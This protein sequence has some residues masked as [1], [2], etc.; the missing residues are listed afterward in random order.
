[1]ESAVITGATGAIGTALINELVSKGVRVLVLTREDSPRNSRIPQSPLVEV[2]YCSLENLHNLEI[3]GEYDVFYH[4]AWAGTFGSARNDF[5]LQNKNVEYALDAVAAAKRMGCR[6]FI[7]AGS[8][9]E[10]GR[11][12]G[13]LKPDTPAFPE[14]GY[15]YAK[16]CAGQMTRDFAHQLGLRH[17][18]VRIL[19]VYGP[20][21][22]SGT[23]VMS[24]L[25]KLRDGETPEFTKGEQRWDYLYS[26]DAAEAF[27]MLGEKGRD[28]MVYVLGSGIARP[29]AEYIEEIRQAAAP[30]GSV[31]LGAVPYGEKQVMFL[32]ADISE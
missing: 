19:S 16:L 32:C 5:Y 17:I 23:M 26:G 10:Y 29:L 22:G 4:L 3:D 31:R 28:G 24:A 1:M 8:Q 20:N 7:G 11:V 12:E 18:W 2:R 25:K 13:V 30:N 14:N 6:T 21:D 15:G 9:A 27:A